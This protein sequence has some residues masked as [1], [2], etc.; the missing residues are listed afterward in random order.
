MGDL[1]PLYPNDQ[2]SVSMSYKNGC[3]VSN[4]NAFICHLFL[5]FVNI[6]KHLRGFMVSCSTPLRFFSLAYHHH[7]LC[8][9]PL[10]H[11]GSRLIRNRLEPEQWFAP[12]LWSVLENWRVGALAR[13]SENTS[14]KHGSGNDLVAN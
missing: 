6:N 12:S 3:T 8:L 9:S 7:H 11:Q 10:L 4:G 2:R 14:Y 1:Q 5:S 13:N